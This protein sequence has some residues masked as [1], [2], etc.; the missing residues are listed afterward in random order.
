MKKFLTQNTLKVLKNIQNG[1]NKGAKIM[2]DKNYYMYLVENITHEKWSSLGETMTLKQALDLYWNSVRVRNKN[3]I[4]ICYKCFDEDYEYKELSP[5]T[6][7]VL[8]NGYDY[9]E[10]GY[11]IVY[12][13][14]V[15][16]NEG[17]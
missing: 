8:D 11:P 1:I 2:K 10:D 9:D 14:I 13:N 5:N 17:V 3:N 6:I 7:I 15:E 12:A 16:E 4:H